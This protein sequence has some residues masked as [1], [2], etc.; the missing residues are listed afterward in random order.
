[1]QTKSL[2]YL[3]DYLE[4]ISGIAGFPYGASHPVTITLARYDVQIVHSMAAQTSQGISLTD[5]QA[6]LAHKL[7]VKYRRQLASNGLDLGVHADNAVFRL[8]V[9][10]VDRTRGIKLQDGLIHIRFPYDDTLLNEIKQSAK[11]TPGRLQFEPD[12]KIWIGSVTE[13]RLIW[14]LHLVDKYD[15][16]VDDPTAQLIQQVYDCQKQGFRIE[17][18]SGSN[19]LEIVN[20]ESSLIDYVNENLGGFG[21]DN[22]VRLIDYS[23]VLGYTVSPELVNQLSCSPR[24]QS[25]LTDRDVH[26]PLSKPNAIQDIV[27]YA[28]ISDR[29][30][31]FVFENNGI[32]AEMLEQ[33]LAK[34]F[35]PEEI[36]YV[37]AGQRKIPDTTGYRCVY[38]SHWNSNWDMRI[39]L[40]ISMTALM[41]GVRRI[42]IVQRSEKVV[43]GTEVVYNQD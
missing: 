12:T 10:M 19:G 11:N 7:V 42:Q 18:V 33:E 26:I 39:P 4:V 9:R 41:V 37:K 24:V 8:P 13:P 21:Q 23:S 22:L 15:F 30:P 1:M 20:A 25:L 38:L 35:R 27:E 32:P 3:E 5:R 40:L 36:L 16:Q 34:V 6:L 31:V 2:P 14:L 29:W 17:L 28:G 43:F